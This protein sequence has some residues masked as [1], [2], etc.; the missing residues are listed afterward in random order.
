MAIDG[1][2]LDGVLAGAVER[3]AVHGVAGLIVH[4]DGVLYDGRAGAARADT[5]YRNASMTKAVATTAALALLEGGR[6]DLD[7]PV[8]AILP[9]W[10]QLQVLDGFDGDRPRLRPPARPATI[11][12]LMTHTSGAAYPF[13]SPE[14]FR[15]CTLT[16]LSPVIDGRRA[17]LM[18]PLVSDPGERWVYG[19]STDWLGLVVEAV[20]GESLS[21]HLAR[22]IYEPL[23]MVDSTFAPDAGQA[24]RLM[25]MMAR[26]PDGT[27]APTGLGLPAAPEWDAAGHGS[28]GTIAD[29]GRFLRLWLRGGELDGV[30]LLSEDTVALALTDQLHG[31]PLPEQMT[32]MVPALT[33]DVPSLPFPQGWGY[34]FHLTGVDLPG[35]RRAGSG[36]WAGIFNCYFWLD[37]ASGVAGV[38]MTQVLPFFD[39]PVVHTF[40]AFEAAAYAAVSAAGI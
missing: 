11:A 8:S 4:R 25:G 17:S 30:R 29:Y 37:R 9:A 3:G 27:L 14:L 16:G 12:E 6:L 20:V 38:L 36:D 31:A 28:Y 40:A 18:A 26:Q 5:L 19:T 21:A 35:M 10:A 34:G 7:S 22:T 24:A 1:S 23:G 15:Y 13:F 2:E 33:R 39:T 32:S